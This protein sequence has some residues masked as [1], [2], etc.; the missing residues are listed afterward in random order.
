MAVM[1]SKDKKDFFKW[2]RIWAV[3][4]NKDFYYSDWQIVFERRKIDKIARKILKK[5][6]IN[7]MI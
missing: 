1:I 6:Y 3:I 2:E 4:R 7:I 5:V